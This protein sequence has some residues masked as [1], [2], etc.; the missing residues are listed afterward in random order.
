MKDQSMGKGG[1][2]RDLSAQLRG[3]GR[4]EAIVVR[5]ERKA[6]ARSVSEAQAV[7]GR[8]LSGDRR[9]ARERR[10]DDARRREV[11]LIQYEHLAPIA[12][13]CGLASVDPCA[14][15]RN[16]VLSGLNLLAMRSPFHDVHFVWRIG[17]DVRI[18]LTGPCDPCS[19]MEEA[20]GA[21]GYNAMRG[22]GGMT[23]RIVTGGTIRVGDRVVLDIGG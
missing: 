18:V 23:A 11:T 6:P 9:A 3:D 15:R 17:D 19:R 21:G 2:L 5:P 16:L 1:A 20:L 8:G 10:G 14:L 12:Q 13:W 22:H 4:I 7:P